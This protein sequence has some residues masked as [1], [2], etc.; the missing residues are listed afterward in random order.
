M[1]RVEL[2]AE[3]TQCFIDQ[4]KKQYNNKQ[5]LRFLI[6]IVSVFSKRLTTY[7]YELFQHNVKL[8]MP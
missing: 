6:M 4:Q 5:K 3:M 2:K 1:M 8:I 7:I